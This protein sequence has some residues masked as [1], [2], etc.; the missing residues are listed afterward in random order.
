MGCL[1][2]YPYEVDAELVWSKD[3]ADILNKMRKVSYK[4]HAVGAFTVDAYK[5]QD[6]V[7]KHKDKEDFCKKYNFLTSKPTL[8]ICSPWGFVDSSPD[9]HIDD[10]DD[11]RKDIEGRDRQLAMIRQLVSMRLKER[12]NILL[13]VHPGVV[14]QPYK[15]L[16]KELDI[17]LDTESTSFYLKCNVDAIIHSGSTMAIGAHYLNIPCYQFGDIY[18]KD[19]KSWWSDPESPISQ[20]SPHYSD[21]LKLF[22]AIQ[23]Y[24]PETNANKEALRALEKGRFGRMDGNA[25]KRAAAIINKVKGKFKLAWPK[26]QNDYT[27][28]MYQRSLRRVCTPTTCGICKEEFAIVNDSYFQIITQH[29][30]QA[31]NP[32]F[33]EP[34][35]PEV[36]QK[37]WKPNYGHACPHCSARFFRYEE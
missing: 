18:C 14:Q 31:F 3:E 32:Y 24:T 1:W 35:P 15:E 25:T 36:I 11:A 34:P 28:L 26:S 30:L 10:L 4:T 21:P 20:I 17:P 19:T 22:G 6:L 29:V 33:K 12:W 8:L 7:D 2:E 13:S 5:R 9:L 16:S 37:M 23:N 27:Q